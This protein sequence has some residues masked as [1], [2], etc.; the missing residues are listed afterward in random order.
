MNR[1]QWLASDYRLCR[2]QG[3]SRYVAAK[4]AIKWF[5]TPVPF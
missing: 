1:F 5:F 2:A 4:K 3:M